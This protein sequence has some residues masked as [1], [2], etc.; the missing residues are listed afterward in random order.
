MKKFITEN[1][2]IQYKNNLG[3]NGT[4]LRKSWFEYNN[5]INEYKK[6]LC[7][8]N[9]LNEKVKMSERLYCIL[10]KINKINKCPYCEK[11]VKYTNF[12]TGY[13]KHCG[14]IKCLHQFKKKFK[15][16]N[17]LTS[18]EKS[19]IGISISQKTLQNNGKTKAQ[20]SAIKS[21]KKMASTFI[22]GLN[23]HQISA[24]KAAN[25]KYTKISFD[26]LNIHQISA[27]KAAN[28]MKNTMINGKSLKEL[29]IEKMYKTKLTIGEDGLNS[30]ERAFFNGAGKN[31]TLK[32]FNSDLFYQGTYELDFLEKI[33][34]WNLIDQIS[35]G[36]TFNYN[37]KNKKRQYRSDFLF[38]NN[39]IFEIKS[40]W[41]YGKNQEIR[42]KNKLKFQSV[43][44]KNLRLFVIFNKEK[45]IE[46]TNKNV[47][48]NLILETFVEIKKLKILLNGSII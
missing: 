4:K 13:R 35:N 25:T 20:N 2:L 27:R 16:K 6:I 12:E 7:L 14:E 38:G 44:N 32:Y 48:R 40:D 34:K 31:S 39:F 22:D 29:R 36:L 17:G 41:T 46:I 18:N 47:D 21:H 15:D 37:L 24:R 11:N 26:G 19:G 43:L 8:T 1:L 5:F 10:N 45:F 28:T 30:F 9:F 3:L 42:D 23:I 33:K